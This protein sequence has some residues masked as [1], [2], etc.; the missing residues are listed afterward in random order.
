MFEYQDIV[1]HHKYANNYDYNKAV[2]LMSNIA[3]LDNGF[4]L[5]KEDASHASPISVLFY[6]YYSKKDNLEQLLFE[7][8]DALQCVVTNLEIPEAI[9][10]GQTQKPTLS[11]YADDV[12]TLAFLRSL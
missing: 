8:K 11:D 12:D 6:E 4:L 3:L 10:F 9:L 1:H 7:N 5:L 2:Y